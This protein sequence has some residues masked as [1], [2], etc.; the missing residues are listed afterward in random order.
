MPAERHIDG[1][2]DHLFARAAEAGV[3]GLAGRLEPRL[4]RSMATR[5]AFAHNGGSL[6]MVH[7]RDP[8]LVD[9]ALL[10]RLAL[11]RLEGE[12]WYWWAIVS[13]EVP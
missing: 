12:N 5:H 13:C 7:G 10:G 2:V 3:G 1:V 6:M 9:D 4:R 8:S 11:S